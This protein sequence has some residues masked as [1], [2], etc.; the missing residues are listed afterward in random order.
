MGASWIYLFIICL[1]HRV[2]SLDHAQW[3]ETQ[4]QTGVEMSL[5]WEGKARDSTLAAARWQEGQ[6][7]CADVVGQGR[8]A[9]SSWSKLGDEGN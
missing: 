9:L 6:W 5:W 4:R 1:S 7:K 3:A 2:A 8:C